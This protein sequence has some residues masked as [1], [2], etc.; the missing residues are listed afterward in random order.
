LGPI[1]TQPRRA[2]P[3]AH[4]PA[5]ARTPPRR[6]LIFQSITRFGMT[7]WVGDPTPNHRLP[8]P[9]QPPP[10]MAPSRWFSREC[11]FVGAHYALEIASVQLRRRVAREGVV[12]WWRLSY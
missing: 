12:A 4:N 5:P 2:G 7:G 11:P 6:G 10:W 8:W 9:H 3:R 1:A